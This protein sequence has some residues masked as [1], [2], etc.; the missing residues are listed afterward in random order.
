[1]DTFAHFRFGQLGLFYAVYV[2]LPSPVLAFINFYNYY[3][4]SA[5]NVAT[6][7]LALNRFTALFRPSDHDKV[8][9]NI[10]N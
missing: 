2:A 5:Q 6:V 10:K 9:L 3:G 8:K 7:F 4:F 1:L